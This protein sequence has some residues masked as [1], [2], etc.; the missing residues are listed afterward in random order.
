MSTITSPII[1][2]VTADIEHRSGPL[3]AEYLTMIDAMAR[4]APGREQLSC[5]NLAH[6]FAACNETDKSAIKLMDSSPKV[7]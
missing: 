1:A 4:Q 2:K 3:R 5:G 7:I 6:G